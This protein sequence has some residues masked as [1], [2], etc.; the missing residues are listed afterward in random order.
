[1]FRESKRRLQP[2]LISNV[3]DLPAKQK[4]RLEDSWAG[5]FFREV[6]ER[7]PETI[8]ADLYSDIPSRPNVPVR[9]LVS[10]EF[11]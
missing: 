7:I 2:I 6:Y 11:L 8:F 1:M 4:K 3:N 10:L 9:L 5:T